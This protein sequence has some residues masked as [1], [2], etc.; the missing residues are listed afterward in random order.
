MQKIKIKNL[1]LTLKSQ[2]IMNIVIT[3]NIKN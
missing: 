1:F 3:N 2:N